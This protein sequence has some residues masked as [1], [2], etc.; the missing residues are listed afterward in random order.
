MATNTIDYTK[1]INAREA[2]YQQQFELWEQVRAVLKGKYA[3]IEIVTCLPSPQYRN[4]HANTSMTHDQRLM[5]E[6]CN[7]L[8]ALRV[9]AYWARG[10]FFNATGRTHE[11]LDGM[12]WSK[13]PEVDLP[14]SLQYMETNSNGT[15]FSLREVTQE[16]TDEVI[17]IGRYGILVDMPARNSRPTMAEQE[18]G[19]LAPRFVQYKA[20]RI[21]YYRLNSESNALEEVR[22]VEFVSEQT[23]EFEWENK[24]RV[25]RLI[26]K[27]G[28]YHNMTYNTDGDLLTDI[29]PMANGQPLNFIPFQ[30]FG[31]DNNS[32][33]YSKVPLY[34]LA[35]INLGHFVLDCDNRDN[36]HFHGQGMTNVYTDMT[37]E[38]F[39]SANPNGLDVGAKG[40]NLLD[41]NDRI[42]I[43]QLEATGAIATEMER[44]EKRMIAIGAQL[45]QDTNTNVTLGAKEMEFGASTSTLK[46][47]S[48]NISS[49]MKNCLTWAGM[50]LNESGDI[51]YKLNTDFVTD[52]LSPAMIKEHFA[53][54][55]GGVLPVETLYET[56]RKAG[57]T[58]KSD[59]DL[60]ELALQ[61]DQGTRGTS[62][63]V[64]TLQ[65]EIDSLR[66]QLAGNE[67]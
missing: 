58:T 12:I 44:D 51:E 32:P 3:V 15:G 45:V 13:E 53:I 38:E 20:E 23:S 62:E 11:S 57:F 46:R 16:V 33:H 41:Q 61:D 30:F 43:L 35:N 56:S 42:E 22:L 25:R 9:Q 14:S 28:V 24:T 6:Q 18:S 21:P 40:R 17:A 8:N 1:G 31:S 26:I 66:Q 60:K 65:A 59:E 63:E 36:L 64:A 48:M 34:D 52:D 27:D 54:V 19:E 5:A 67:E 49:G 7:A 37:A 2:K 47:I 10:R 55:Q 29:V 39:Q 50:F 4:Y